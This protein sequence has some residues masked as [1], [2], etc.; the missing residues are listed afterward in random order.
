MF[1]GAVVRSY[2]NHAA[3]KS[4]LCQDF[5]ALHTHIY[6]LFCCSFSCVSICSAR[7]TSAPSS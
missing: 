4:K 2:L 7:D 3:S 6:S 5:S 1:P